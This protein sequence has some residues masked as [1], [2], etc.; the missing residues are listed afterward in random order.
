MP[1]LTTFLFPK[2]VAL[3]APTLTFVEIYLAPRAFS[4]T[5]VE[6]YLA[7]LASSLTFVEIYLA[8]LAPPLTL[9]E[10]CPAPPALP[11]PQCPTRQR[12]SAEEQPAY[13]PKP[14]IYASRTV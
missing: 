6:I 1:T 13:I 12:R 4:L 10:V 14:Y 8:P 5:F 7:P 3:L 9:V 2:N 11:Q